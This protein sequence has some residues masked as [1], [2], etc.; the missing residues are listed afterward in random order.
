MNAPTPGPFRSTQGWHVP[1][2]LPPKPH[3]RTSG[4]TSH[5]AAAPWKPG[6]IP[7]RPLSLVD[8]FNGSVGYVRANPGPTLGLTTAVVLTTTVLGFLGMLAAASSDSTVQSVAG[9][10]IGVLAT[11]LAATLLS[12]MLTTIVARSVLGSPITVTEAWQRVRGR[13]AALIVL[14]MLEIASATALIGLAALTV[15]AV[16][17]AAGGRIAT[18]VGAPLVLLL[19]CALTYLATALALAPVAI[20]LERRNVADAIR[21]SLALTRRRFWR[22]LAVLVLAGVVMAVVTGAVSLPFDVAASVVSFNARPRTS[23]IVEPMVATMGQAVGQII[24]A[25]FIAGVVT[26]LYVDARIRLE[27]F[28]FT[29]LRVPAG[30]T[31]TDE[32]WLG[33]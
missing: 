23:G 21:R 26:L 8:I 27:A 19:I 24:T 30:A 20:V 5:P 29:L 6:V 3:P 17:R 12:G 15:V 4:P 25:P 10:A 28:D 11:I 16:A 32:L 9:I 33:H 22:T 14:T 31:G 2:P 7:L 1:N 18:L 13:L